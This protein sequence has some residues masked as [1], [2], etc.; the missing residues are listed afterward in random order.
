VQ[1]L[2]VPATR[3]QPAG[4]LIDDD[5]P[6]LLSKLLLEKVPPSQQVPKVVRTEQREYGHGFV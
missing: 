2:A 3:H 4:E 5:H 6:D 1:P